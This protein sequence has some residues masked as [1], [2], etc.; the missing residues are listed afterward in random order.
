MSR[1][2]I[3]PYRMASNSS[4]ALAEALREVGHKVIRVYPDRNYT[5]RDDDI[6]ID[7]GNSAVPNWEHNRLINQPERVSIAANKRHTF[8]LL[9][10][11]LDTPTP[12]HTTSKNVA[13]YWIELGN[14]IFCRTTLTGHSGQ[15]IVVA[16]TPEELVDAPLYTLSFTKTN[17]YRIHVF[18]N[19]IIDIQEKKKRSGTGVRSDHDV[20]NLGNDYIFAREGVE[21]PV[22]AQNS[23]IMAV[24]HLGL[25][26]GA[27]D[28]GYNRP[29]DS[30]VVFEVNTSPGL[31][32]TTLQ[33]YVERIGYEL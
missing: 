27:V 10:W 20:W 18:K 8:D 7:W 15:G 16:T 6:I 25:D 23:A 17:E 24:H 5:P 28:V 11:F 9:E 19:E 21:C 33:K 30:H 2:C 13:S 14:Q 32:G 12:S 3:Y 1:I 4:K 31:E 22:A 26:F 29:S